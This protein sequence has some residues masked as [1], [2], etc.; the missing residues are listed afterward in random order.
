M[1][2][3]GPFESRLP[4]HGSCLWGP[5]WKQSTF[6]LQL[7]L[8]TSLKVE[9]LH[10][11]AAVGGHLRK[12]ATYTLQLLLRALWKQS[13]YT[14]QYYW[15]PLWKQSRPLTSSGTPGVA[16]SFPRGAQIFL[17]MSNSFKLC[18]T[19]FYR[20][21]KNFLGRASP[22]SDYGHEAEYLHI[23]AAVGVSFRNRLL[24]Y[25]SGCWR[26]FWKL[27]A[28]LLSASVYIIWVDNM[29][30]TETEENLPAKHLE[31][32]SLASP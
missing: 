23:A 26:P 17:T 4:T 3:G 14:L 1:A 7:I 16:K 2:T 6:T 22:P 31:G 18:R 28:Y 8:W 21:A 13:T 29:I 30:V 24:T 10:I 19:H 32:V 25:Y 27:S 11:T 9:Y 5:F 20:R 12:Q 15:V